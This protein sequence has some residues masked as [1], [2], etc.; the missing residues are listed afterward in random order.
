MKLGH[1]INQF[2]KLKNKKEKEDKN[3]S[4]GSA[5]LLVTDSKS[6]GYVGNHCSSS[7]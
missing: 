1:E 3:S 2:Y 5:E 4:S 7:N 6:N